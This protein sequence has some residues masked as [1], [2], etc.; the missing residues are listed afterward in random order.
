M[1]AAAARAHHPCMAKFVVTAWDAAGGLMPLLALARRLGERGHDVRL[2]GNPSI[3]RKYCR[4]GWRFR[5][6]VET[7]D[8]DVTAQK[9]MSTEL[10]VNSRNLWFNP[11]VARDL[12][13][14]LAEE[15]ADLIVVDC[16]LWAGLSGAVA[17]ETPTAAFFH[18]P[19][20]A[21]VARDAMLVPPLNE[22]RAGMGLAPLDSVADLYRQCELCIVAV[23]REL[24]AEN[25]NF[26]SCMHW[27]GPIL[28]SPALVTEA[29]ELPELDGERFALISLGTGYQ[30]QLPVLQR[31]V[32]A[33]GEIPRRFLVTTGP[34]VAPSDLMLSA[35]VSATSYVPHH[36]L[37]PH[38]DLVITHAGL[39]TIMASLRHG[40]PLLCLPLGRDQF[41]NA[42][43]VESRGV[44][45]RLPA[46]SDVAAISATIDDL[47]AE[48][49]GERS[50]ARDLVPVFED[51]SGADAAVDSLERIVAAVR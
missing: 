42:Q 1:T 33:A 16:M 37:L 20:S 28:D 39:G 23:P 3:D 2:L 50:A 17:S 46:D 18:Q 11:A 32:G 7:P 48:D 35:N 51:R 19:Y 13:A 12:A 38:A 41:A 36:L 15:P 26:P 47:L 31:L 27:V 6:F 14:A 4:Q 10:P 34:A 25:F 30:A 40:V 49:A 22:A 44:G 8:Y 43:W 5:A 21:Y 45:R 9:D 29:S 24:E